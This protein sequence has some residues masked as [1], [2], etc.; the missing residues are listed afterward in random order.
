MR[1]GEARIK[2]MALRV[3][4]AAVAGVVGGTLL[5]F[6]VMVWMQPITIAS[7]LATIGG[8]LVV[9]SLTSTWMFYVL[10]GKSFRQDGHTYCG[11]CGYILKSLTEPRCSECGQVI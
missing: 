8:G 6:L 3:L 7:T 10:G 2:N 4:A 5:L 9:S 11:H 1:P